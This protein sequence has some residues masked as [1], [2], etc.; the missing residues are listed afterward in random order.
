MSVLIQTT[1]GDVT[2]DL[3]VDDCP[4]ACRNFLQL[5]KHKKYNN[6][7][8]FNVQPG[9]IAQTGDPTGTGHGGEACRWV[10][11]APVP[12]RAHKI[13]GD[14]PPGLDHTQRGTV[15]MAG[16]S[17][18][19]ARF[20]GPE[21]GSQFFITLSDG[22]HASLDGLHT[23]IGQVVEGLETLDRLDEAFADAA[24]RPLVDI[25][26]AHTVV[27]DDPLG[28]PVA[29]PPAPA[30]PPPGRPVAESVPERLRATCGGP[31][32]TAAAGAAAADDQA[33][34]VAQRERLADEETKSRAVVLEMVG[35]LPDADAAPPDN[36]LFV[37][38]LNPVTKSADLEMI[39]S[40]FGRVQSC[41]IL[42][43]SESG[44][45]L[46]YAFVEFATKQACEEAF[47]KMNN[48]MIDNRRIKVDFSQSV[49]RFASFGTSDTLHSLFEA[50]CARSPTAEAVLEVDSGESVTFAELNGL[51]DNV[52]R[53]LLAREGG[54][55]GTRGVVAIFAARSIQTLACILGVL[56][57]GFAYLPVDPGQ[58]AERAQYL[59][60]DS[61][62]M[63]V[64][65]ALSLSAAAA[66]VKRECQRPETA[67][68]AQDE[69]CNSDARHHLSCAAAGSAAASAAALGSASLATPSTQWAVGE[70]PDQKAGAAT[71]SSLAY[72]I[73]TSGSTGKPKGVGVEHRSAVNYM[74]AS[75]T[76]YEPRSSDR[77]LQFAS[78]SFDASV[79]EV[80][81]PLCNGATVVLRSSEMTLSASDFM[82]ACESRGV[83]VMSCATAFWHQLV[84]SVTRGETRVPGS[85]RLVVI[86]GEA[87]NPSRLVAWERAC[88]GVPVVNA[89]GPTEATV[90]T[91]LW[92]SDGSL[93][94]GCASVPIGRGLPGV[95]SYVLDRERRTP[96]PVGVVGELYVGG[97]CLARGYLGRDDLTADRFV[98]DPFADDVSRSVDGRM[99]ATG[100][101]VRMGEDGTLTYVGRADDQVKI[102]G[103]RIELGEIEEVARR[104]DSVQDCVVRVVKVGGTQHLVGY[105]VW[106]SESQSAASLASLREGMSRSLPS[107]MVPSALLELASIPT[108]ALGKID[109][110]A[111]PVPSE[112]DFVSSESYVAPSTE[113]EQALADVWSEVLQRDK[114]GVMD[115]F[116]ELG[117]DSI[118]SLQVV[119]LCGQRGLNVRPKLLFEHPTIR[120]LAQQVDGCESLQRRT[121]VAG[122]GFA[123]SCLRLSAMLGDV[124]ETAQVLPVSSLQAAMLLAHASAWRIEG[125]LE[126][127]MSQSE[128]AGKAAW[129]RVSGGLLAEPFKLDIDRG[130]TL[131]TMA[132]PRSKWVTVPGAGR[133]FSA[134]HLAA[135][136]TSLSTFSFGAWLLALEAMTSSDSG[137]RRAVSGM[138]VAIRPSEVADCDRLLGLLI[139][140]VPVPFLWNDS[141]SAGDALRR[142]QSVCLEVAEQ[143]HWA[144]SKIRQWCS[145]PDAEAAAVELRN[146]FVFENYPSASEEA[147]QRKELVGVTD[148]PLT[149]TCIPGDDETRIQLAWQPALVSDADAHRLL[150]LVEANLV[151]LRNAA[152]ANALDSTALPAIPEHDLSIQADELPSPAKESS[153]TLW[154]LVKAAVAANPDAIAVTDG[155]DSITYAELDRRSALLAAALQRRGAGAGGVVG[156]LLGRSVDAIVSLVSVL[157]CGAAYLP[158]DPGQPVSRL[159]YMVEDS[160]VGVVLVNGAS[161]GRAAES[162]AAMEGEGAAARVRVLDVTALGGAVGEGASAGGAS[163]AGGGAAVGED[164]GAATPSSLAYIIYTSGSTG[165][166]KGVGVEHRSAV[167]YMRAS[168]T[169]YEPRSS[170]RWLQF[171]SLSFDASVEEVF[172]PLCNGATVVLR[173]SEMTLSA[174]DFMSACESRGVTVMSCA[175]AFWHQLVDSVTRGETRVPGSVRLVVIGGE[176]CNPS[177]LVAWERACPGVPVVNAYGPTEATVSTHLW[178]SDGSLSEG[179]ASVPIGRGL[180]GVRSYVL[181]R[182]RRTPVPVGVVGELYVGGLCLARGYLGR[183]DLTADRFVP[184]PF[185]DDV[186]RSVDG[187]MY[188]TGDLVRM[189]EDGTLTYVGRADDQVKIRGFRIELGEIEEVARRHDSVQDCVVRVVKVGGTQHLVGYV[190]WASESQSTASLASLREGMS[191]S[192][193]SYM[194][195]S[196]LLELASI[197]TTAL[198]KIDYRA[199]P[200]PSE[201]DFVSSESYVAPSTEV[202]QA[203]ADVWSEVLQR[204]KHVALASAGGASVVAAEQGTVSGEVP[205]TPIQRWFFSQPLVN[206]DHFNMSYSLWLDDCVTHDQLGRSLEALALFHDAMG[207]RFDA[208]EEAAS[209]RV[210]QRCVGAEQRPGSISLSV[211]SVDGLGEDEAV[212]IDR[213]ATSASASLDISRGPIASAVV[214]SGGASPASRAGRSRRVVLAV[215]HLVVDGVSWRVLLRDLDSLLQGLQ[216]SGPTLPSATELAAS[217]GRKSSSFREW[218]GR[219]RGHAEGSASLAAEAKFWSAQ[220]AAPL[221]TVRCDSDGAN[222]EASGSEVRLAFDEA[223]TDA[224][225]KGC[226]AALGTRI[227]DLLLAA[228]AASLGR[229]LSVSD[230]LVEMEAHGR[231]DLFDDIDLSRTVGWFTAS[232]PVRVHGGDGRDMV[233]V[234]KSAKQALRSVPNHGIGYGLLAGTGAVPSD[235]GIEVSFNYLGVFDSSSSAT[236]SGAG[237]AG[238]GRRPLV[239]MER[240]N[241]GHVIDGRNERARLL[242]VNAEVVDGLL[243]V[244]LGYSRFRHHPDTMK[245]VGRAFE[246]SLRNYLGMCS[247]GAAIGRTPSDFPLCDVSQPELDGIL[248]RHDLARVEDMYALTPM[249]QGMLFH[250]AYAESPSEDVYFIQDWFR[251]SGCVDLGAFQ[252]AW[253]HVVERHAILRTVFEW[254][255]LAA[256]V[257]VVLKDAG[258]EWRESDLRGLG[259]AEQAAALRR[260]SVEDRERGFDLR[261]RPPL[262]MHGFRVSDGEARVLL[263]VHHVLVDGWSN[264]IIAGEVHDVYAAL[265]SGGSPPRRAPVRCPYSGY[266]QWLRGQSLSDAE[267]FWRGQ[268]Q[269]LESP[270][271]LPFRS[272]SEGR[273][274]AAVPMGGYHTLEAT[275]RIPGASDLRRSGLTLNTLVCSSWSL[276]L[277]QYTGEPDVLFGVTVAGRPASLK[278]VD[279]A[280]GLFINTVALR[281]PIPSMPP[282]VT[283]GSSTRGSGCGAWLAEVQSRLSSVREFE[284]TPLSRLQG[285]S[286]MGSEGS[287]FHTLVVFENYPAEDHPSTS[288]SIAYADSDEKERT[289]FPVVLTVVPHPSGDS[290]EMELGFYDGRVSAAQAGRLLDHLSGLIQGLAGAAPSS[291]RESLADVVVSASRGCAGGQSVHWAGAP[292]SRDSADETLWSLVK[293]AVAANPDAIAVTDG[294]DSITYAELDRRS[295]LLAAA[296]QRRGA[297]AGGVVGVLLGRSVDAIVSL[298]SVLRCGAAYLPLDPGQP[299][300]RL[301]YMV[302]D[303]G[304]GW[305]L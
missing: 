180:P 263:S 252:A 214:V 99:Y 5:C 84:D 178:R 25:R 297:G 173:S 249:Q 42:K 150:R 118:L 165:K 182:E 167:N 83:T 276:L 261:S 228:L 181:D 197:P 250:S 254:E 57:A 202:E 90:S 131:E 30:S 81:V 199:L 146:L 221:P 272:L 190:V 177:R 110:R 94:E 79:E 299:V 246:L 282:A 60:E 88:P 85:V 210:V 67:W 216:R 126:W 159:A 105:V 112:E 143:G 284:H 274:G 265:V 100:D 140:T 267:D 270:T 72:I 300:S 21:V 166:P 243:S 273:E 285:W 45:S 27:L 55:G 89:Y 115:S 208:S 257:Q 222:T 31:G 103:F 56:K 22:P 6:C 298:V 152:V 20:R 209:I 43:D 49:A 133:I 76:V 235:E 293:A 305:C 161:S 269:G 205:L 29:A 149:L 212:A 101:L 275:V 163:A 95:R 116:F 240:A 175:T 248:A 247:S 280:V 279:E 14:A 303:S 52:A 164:A 87:C 188:A 259:E 278:H 187:R 11:H 51:A 35:D 53:W 8:F 155:S 262:R 295:A 168:A 38:K 93:S 12:G 253:S 238:A 204:D 174:S 266:V 179:C 242:E 162:L 268:L 77:W 39:F 68:V 59:I 211:A 98:P 237:A 213:I 144:W 54:G 61:G 186:S 128:V 201:E 65:F 160:G 220:L 304:V 287:L 148:V 26:I 139:N 69:A 291:S 296:L 191:R 63:T 169:V 102:R 219:L 120:A 17:A 111:L 200:V 184:D 28:S 224:L 97:L 142:L 255:G 154:S 271:P 172:V 258:L 192:L 230:T 16:P 7:L 225:L 206:R 92:R 36:V 32:E 122:S 24:G 96:V 301:A 123:A 217:L 256:P 3:N 234:V 117:G 40:R 121:I 136:R 91:H 151:E 70:G 107:Y 195:P 245:E 194:V 170:D 75:A 302:E 64:L 207:L 277:W 239:G 138:T 86:G 260:A 119:S 183:D 196:A 132:G 130:D 10:G 231:E 218:S 1:V 229:V 73:Y 37:C 232:Y 18:G 294:S 264:S 124:S 62:A 48:V 127:T 251:V 198:G 244:E 82:S 176:A 106:A 226:H 104:H 50:S 283:S 19:S 13:A 109:Y 44:E 156:V 147:V 135:S 33:A 9:F 78:L 134:R 153:S 46:C 66:A 292:S 80:F 233:A 157:R 241:P 108:T 141:E 4:N 288:F 203:L 289:N 15:S 137:V 171:A 227:E 223:T 74:R 215:H 129:E 281:V 23:P 114:V 47:F 290:L 189:G 41:E 286:D 145:S 193:P 125:W 185:A 58:P 113:V 34:A 71:P 158:L 2:V 236:A